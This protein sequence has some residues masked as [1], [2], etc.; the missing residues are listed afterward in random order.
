METHF[1]HLTKKS[2]WAAKIIAKIQRFVRWNV[3]TCKTGPVDFKL[4]DNVKPILFQPYL[5]PKVNKK[6]VKKDVEGLVLLGVL[7]ITNDLELGSP[8][9][10]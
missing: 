6:L 8:S 2:Y 9:F 1:Q 3:G 4:K 7:E 10:T 5:L